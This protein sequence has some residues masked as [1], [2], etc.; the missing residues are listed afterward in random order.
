METRVYILTLS[1]GGIRT[2]KIIAN[3]VVCVGGRS[4]SWNVLWR[5]SCCDRGQMKE[6]RKRKTN[7]N[8][9]EEAGIFS[10]SR[11]DKRG[12]VSWWSTELWCCWE[13]GSK[14]YHP[15]RGYRCLA[16][17]A[18]SKKL[19][20]ALTQGSS[21]AHYWSSCYYLRWSEG[22]RVLCKERTLMAPC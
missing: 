14:S 22:I 2:G 12:K 21:Y 1:L 7:R 13:N 18:F 17:S 10:H 4:R 19:P 20:K 8:K 11:N 6:I 5:W 15:R 16:I 9:N 3:Q